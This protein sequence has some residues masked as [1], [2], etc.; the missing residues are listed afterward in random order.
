VTVVSK[1][2]LNSPDQA[3]QIREITVTASDG[4]TIDVPP[5]ADQPFMPQ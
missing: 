4:T 5:P 2:G 1:G 3:L